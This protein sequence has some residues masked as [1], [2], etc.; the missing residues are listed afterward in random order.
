MKEA[1][2][3]ELVEKTSLA[4]LADLNTDVVYTHVEFLGREL[5]GP[6]DLYQRWERQQWSATEI[7]FSV[8]RQQWEGLHRGV[9]DQL[10]GTFGGFFYGEQAV[11][12]TLSPLVMGAPDEENR[13]FLSTQVVDEA[14]HSYFFARVYHDVLGV[15]GGLREALAHVGEVR[16]STGGYGRIFEPNGG[17]LV[18]VTDAVRR[19]PR[20]YALWVQGIT[21][22]HLMIE[23]LLALPGQR[24]I[25]RLLRASDLLPGF[26]AGF[27]AVTRDESRHVSYGVWALRQAVRNGHEADIRTVVDRLLP[28]CFGVYA[29]AQVKLP[30]PRNLPPTARLDPR[31]QWAFSVEALTKRLRS[32]GAASD[33]IAGVD[34]R[35]WELIWG[36]VARYEQH[37]G[38]EHPVRRWERGE[39]TAAAVEAS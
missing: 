12:D 28:H 17:E 22:Y 31:E 2:A 33:Y 26:R 19:D 13:L 37:H 35:A 25:L 15:A 24:R 1:E 4:G 21:L 11:T 27:T 36:G 29:N 34:R 30:D 23:A 16:Q 7:D 6:V 38:E 39:V 20:N 9:R 18:T 14:R 32:A 5:P 10:E 8:D 3:V